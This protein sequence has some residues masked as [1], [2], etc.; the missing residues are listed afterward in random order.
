MELVHFIIVDLSIWRDYII[1]IDLILHKTRAYRHL[2][3][4]KLHIGSSLDKGIL[5]QFIVMHIVLDAFRISVSKNNKADGDSSRS[6]LS[7]ICNCSEVLGDALLGN[8]IFT[9][10]LLLGVSTDSVSHH[11]FE[12]CQVIS[13]DNDGLGVS[14]I[15]YIHRRNIC[16]LIKC[17]SPESGDTVPKSP[18]RWGL[19]HGA[20][21]KALDGTVAHV[22]T[23]NM[24]L[25]RLAAVLLQVF[26]QSGTGPCRNWKTG[27]HPA[28]LC[29]EALQAERSRSGERTPERLKRQ[30][31]EMGRH[32]RLLMAQV[33]VATYLPCSRPE[34]RQPADRA[35]L[36]SDSFSV[37]HPL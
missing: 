14:I 8:I 3:F 20:R 9:A 10:M 30:S 17:C 26:V 4:N 15:C 23:M 25:S 28:G 32:F 37:V 33:G 21:G 1:L 24:N 18:L 29:T 27:T 2:L 7:T 34:V 13:S 5:C 11:H 22:D 6:T 19:L 36:P 12:L 31:V 35:P 16:S